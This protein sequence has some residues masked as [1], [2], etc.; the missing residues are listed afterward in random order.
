MASTTVVH[1][2]DDIDGSEAERTVEFGVD[3]V[4]YTI[5]LS[6]AHIKALQDALAVYMA[7]ARRVGRGR[8]GQAAVIP[9]S[10]GSATAA[11]RATKE[12]N[13]QIRNWATA[14]GQ[15][16]ADRGRIPQSVVEA[17]EAA[18]SQPAVEPPPASVGTTKPAKAR[19]GS[20]PPAATFS[21]E[22]R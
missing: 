17:Y 3:G 12:R 8:V 1:F 20:K 13:A 10:R 21:A 5:D 6:T 4:S 11:V 7:H 19:R 16:L 14:T 22:D 9:T 18:Q 15:Q 2:I